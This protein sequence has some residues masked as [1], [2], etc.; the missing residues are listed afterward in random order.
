MEFCPKCGTRL[1]YKSKSKVSLYCAKCKSKSDFSGTKFLKEKTVTTK[2]FDTGIAVVDR[3][4]QKLRTLPIVNS[5][6]QK[7]EGKKA[8]TWSIAF[9][10]EDN[11]QA[12]FFRCISCG[13]TWRLTE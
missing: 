4:I 6:C 10:S 7:C 9:G 2:R 13:H 3:Q 8:E 11:S 5:L 1:I 12:T